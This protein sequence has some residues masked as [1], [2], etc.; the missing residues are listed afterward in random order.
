[1]NDL[2][3]LLSCFREKMPL[4]GPFSYEVWSMVIICIPLYVIIMGLAD[5]LCFGS[6]DW[7]AL[8]GFTLRV[9]LSENDSNL[10]ENRR[11]YKKILLMFWISSGTNCIK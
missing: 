1:M 8:I 2:N 4:T 3:M 9:V 11:A 6:V 5:Y 10:P 7:E